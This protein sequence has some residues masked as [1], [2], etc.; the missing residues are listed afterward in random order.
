MASRSQPS[1]HV[2]RR[3]DPRNPSHVARLCSATGA[4][5][6]GPFWLTLIYSCDKW[7]GF[8]DNVEF[9]FIYNK[10][11]ELKN[12]FWMILVECNMQNY[13]DHP[14]GM[15]EVWNN[16]LFRNFNDLQTMKIFWRMVPLWM[17]AKLQKWTKS[18]VPWSRLP[19][20][21]WNC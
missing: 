8:W 2:E 16:D 4:L 20:Q 12:C 1:W 7:M 10:I 3:F 14:S 21:C 5:G 17:K 19:A 13:Q 18:N 9:F 15:K 6:N 11:I